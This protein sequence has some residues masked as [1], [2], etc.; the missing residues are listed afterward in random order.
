MK[1][2][3][4]EGTWMVNSSAVKANWPS[5]PVTICE[6]NLISFVDGKKAPHNEQ[7][8]NLY[9][10]SAAKDLRDALLEAR[11]LLYLLPSYQAEDCIK[12]INRAI[13]KSKRP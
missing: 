12:S 8:A 5:N 1:N 9:L 7:V 6:V 2:K 11:E 13:E 10:I 4:T 3:E